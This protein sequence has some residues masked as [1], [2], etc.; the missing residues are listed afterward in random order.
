MPLPWSQITR[1]LDPSRW[2]IETA[3]K[4]L[5]AASDPMAELFSVTTD[6]GQLLERLTQRLEGNAP[7]I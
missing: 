2:T 6:V 5:G 1:R 7:R 4:R 3:P